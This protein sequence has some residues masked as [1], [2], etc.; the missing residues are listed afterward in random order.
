MFKSRYFTDNTY[1]S[2]NCMNVGKID[3][4]SSIRQNYK[5]MSCN[6]KGFNYF[7]LIILGL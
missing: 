4:I 2:L 7:Y 5:T 1:T 6:L 3:S